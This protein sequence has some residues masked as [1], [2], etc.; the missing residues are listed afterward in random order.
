MER[1]QIN[2]TTEEYKNLG[3]ALG[4]RSYFEEYVGEKVEDWVGQV[5][6]LAEFGLSPP[7]ASYAAFT[8]GLRHWCTYFLKTLPDIADL[9]EPLERAISDVLIPALLEHQVTETERDLL[10]LPVHMGGFGLESPVSQSRHEYEASIKA[11]APLV[12]QIDKQAVE[13]PN[14]AS[15]SNARVKRK[16]T[17]RGTT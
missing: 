12:K 16:L 5:I 2:I 13:P 1:Q 6:K 7:K 3:A 14:V 10:A 8:F 4:S 17:V 15:R 11:T 9:L